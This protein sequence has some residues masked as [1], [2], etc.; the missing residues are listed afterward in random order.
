M[1]KMFVLIKSINI[2]KFFIQPAPVLEWALLGPHSF[3]SGGYRIDTDH[4]DGVVSIYFDGYWVKQLLDTEEAKRWCAR[5]ARKRGLLPACEQTCQTT[6]SE[7]SAPARN[8][9]HRSKLSGIR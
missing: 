5:D 4:Y 3:Q 8:L 1:K 6:K 7:N 9:L 2:I